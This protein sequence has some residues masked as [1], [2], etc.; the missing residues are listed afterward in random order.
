MFQRIADTLDVVLMV[1]T[2]IVASVGLLYLTGLACITLLS[3]H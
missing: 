3:I 2:A 1:A